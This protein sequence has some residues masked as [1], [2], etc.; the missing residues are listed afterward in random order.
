MSV[1]LDWANQEKTA[2]LC[3]LV[4]RWTWGEIDD[5]LKAGGSLLESVDHAVDVICDV[6][7]MSILP[8]DVISRVKS[9][10]LG[11]SPKFG[12]LI[13]VG[14]DANLR[15]FWDTFTS[16]P[17]AARLKAEYFDTLDEAQQFVRGG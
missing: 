12:R 5:A 17:Y 13:I 3:S 9:H 7:R 16:L 11:L 14:A 2:I 8:P 4:G 10:Y 1:H 6:T 15:L